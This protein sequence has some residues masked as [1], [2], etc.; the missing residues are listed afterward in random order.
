LLNCVQT[1]C[2]VITHSQFIAAHAKLRLLCNSLVG[3]S[4]FQWYQMSTLF[5][6]KMK[7]IFSTPHSKNFI[8]GSD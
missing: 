4:K 5:I 2:F 8:P 1:K 6:T 3:G 7:S